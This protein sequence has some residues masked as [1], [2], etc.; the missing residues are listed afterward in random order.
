MAK[1]LDDKG[2][3][4]LW[5][6]IKSVFATKTDVGN[7]LAQKADTTY[8]NNQ[9]A[10]KMNNGIIQTYR[11]Q[12]VS[13]KTEGNQNNVV[14]NYHSEQT[15]PITRFDFYA[16]QGDKVKA[17]IG[18]RHISCYDIDAGSLLKFNGN[19]ARIGLK[20]SQ[21]EYPM[22]TLKASTTEPY[23]HGV[24][25]GGG[26]SVVIGAG[27]S[28]GTVFNSVVPN[29]GDES[30][31]ISAD[32]IICF[33]PGQQNGFSDKNT[34][35]NTNG[36]Y[37]MN[38]KKV[39]TEDKLSTLATKADTLPYKPMNGGLI[40]QENSSSWGVQTGQETASWADNT[41]GGLKIRRNCPIDGQMSLVI[42]GT[43][44]VNEGNN[45]VYH[46]GNLIFSLSGS[47]LTITKR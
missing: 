41:G 21:A 32:E 4:K 38:N 42:D 31:R 20:N 33:Y 3:S 46:D 30:V 13:F 36:E 19:E 5:N 27:E 47:T 6:K 1:F 40:P 28:A 10:K 22:I 15:N 29:P 34:Y 7:S 25:I 24:L 35:I 45:A 11:G 17:D 18:C 8:V 23:G 43:V 44:Y 16:G 12:E 9:L 2:V 14:F 26:G 37:I 39:V